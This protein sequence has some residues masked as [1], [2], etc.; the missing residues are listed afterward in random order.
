MVFAYPTRIR[1][2]IP[3]TDTHTQPTEKRGLL[4]MVSSSMP[5]RTH[6]SP[7]HNGGMSR[8]SERLL[9]VLITLA[10]YALSTSYCTFSN[11]SFLLMMQ[12]NPQDKNLL[13]TILFSSKN[14][15]DD[16]EEEKECD[17]P[18]EVSPASAAAA[19]AAAATAMKESDP[20][21]PTKTASSSLVRRESYHFFSSES[22]SDWEVRQEIARSS[23]STWQQGR[24]QDQP[25]HFYVSTYEP[26]FSCPLLTRVSKKRHVCNVHEWN[27]IAT[28][29]QQ[30]S[31]IVYSFLEGHDGEN[32][33]YV[34][35]EAIQ[36]RIPNPHNCEI[37][38]F[39]PT[40]TTLPHSYYREHHMTYHEW[41]IVSKR[42][43]PE[44]SL[45]KRQS[46]FMY[47]T[48]E[49]S[50]KELRHDFDTTVLDLVMV[51]CGDKGCE[52]TDLDND[53]V[54]APISQL[55]LVTHGV[56]PVAIRTYDLFTKLHTNGGFVLYNKYFDPM[57]TGPTGGGPTSSAT[58]PVGTTT[59][60]WSFLRLHPSFLQL[61]NATIPDAF[62]Q[63]SIA[64]W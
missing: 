44:G 58:N 15:D 51:D 21:V 8:S 7:H 23:R 16:E 32:E 14:K 20:L 54:E 35:E 19:A 55:V 12:Q 11:S 31:C 41:G 53:F 22:E 10:I 42:K 30:P 34:A 45:L 56:A 50:M 43:A 3:L 40:P 48:L 38:I 33:E 29:R 39:R 6:K 9:W 4:A 37:H 57:E 2:R 13:P 64:K 26:N 24:R 63:E 5:S 62:P 61:N 27:N 28:K 25:P 59:T 47:K 49:R 36:Q 60:V 46:G 18:N 1:S 52:W 17:C